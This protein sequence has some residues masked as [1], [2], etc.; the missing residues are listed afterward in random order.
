V[1]Y[2]RVCLVLR[3]FK[4]TDCCLGRSDQEQQQTPP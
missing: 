1:R 3:H 2:V 4:A